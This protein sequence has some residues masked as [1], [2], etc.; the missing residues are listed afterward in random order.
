[1]SAMQGDR[2]F[3]R[4]ISFAMLVAALI[5]SDYVVAQTQETKERNEERAG[6]LLG[7]MK[8]LQDK[9]IESAVQ[10]QISSFEPVIRKDL[11][12]KDNQ[13][14]L[15]DV[16]IFVN[17]EG[18]KVLNSVS[19][20]GAGKDID[21]V[22][23]NALWTPQLKAASPDG[24]LFDWESSAL[25]WFTRDGD[26]ISRKEVTRPS[27]KA[28]V[29]RALDPLGGDWESFEPDDRFRISCKKTTCEW[30]EKRGSALATRTSTLSR[31]GDDFKL[32]RANDEA[33]LAFLGFQPS[34]RAEILK[35]SPESSFILLRR[36]G[37]NLSA[38]WFGITA[39]KDDKAKLKE[40]IQPSKA[41]PAK[42]TFKRAP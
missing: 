30:T 24:L 8:Y 34:L 16:R 23:I 31:E 39:R 6:W 13:G 18:S 3:I 40:L 7:V 1:M 36:D 9:A 22:L 33:T 2:R 41:K 42:Y 37:N 20:L 19:Y 15:V 35:Q 28:T 17:A 12:E 38:R 29:E 11:F 26:A 27:Y 4:G 10:K 5:P 14:V 32:T 25:L 21:S